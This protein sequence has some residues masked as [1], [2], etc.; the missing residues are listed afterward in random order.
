MAVNE[1]IIRGMSTGENSGP[2]WKMGIYLNSILK[3][4][5]KYLLLPESRVESCWS[6]IN[7]LGGD[8][9]VKNDRNSIG[10]YSIKVSCRI[11]LNF[12]VGETS[13][14]KYRFIDENQYFILPK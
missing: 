3:H 1:N 10:S 11:T 12:Y 7:K 8:C 9:K 5:L 13:L 14:F 6:K 4:H 2:G